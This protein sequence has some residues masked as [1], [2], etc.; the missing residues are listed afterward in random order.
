MRPNEPAEHRCSIRKYDTGYRKVCLNCSA[1][2]D[3]DEKLIGVARDLVI[4]EC[5]TCEAKRLER[6]KRNQD[7][8]DKYKYTVP[9]K[10]QGYQ[11][12]PKRKTEV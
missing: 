10:Y 6:I 8:R 1:R 9:V 2:F 4:E 3:E 7:K 12:K 5:V 11:H